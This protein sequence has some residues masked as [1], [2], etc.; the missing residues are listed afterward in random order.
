[1]AAPVWVSTRKV[2]YWPMKLPWIRSPTFVG[3]GTETPTVKP[4]M[5]RPRRVAM[6][7]VQDKPGRAAGQATALDDHAN[8][9]VVAIERGGSSWGP[10]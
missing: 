6:R 10:N 7:C 2:S 3:F 9:G 4:S 8:L 1:M 5:A